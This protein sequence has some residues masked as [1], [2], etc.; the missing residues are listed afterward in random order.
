MD[1]S[2]LEPK[3]FFW[4]NDAETS[5]LNWIEALTLSLFLKLLSRK[6]TPFDSFY[7]ASSSLAVLYLSKVTIWPCTEYYCHIYVADHRCSWEIL[8][9]QQKQL[10]RAVGPSLTDSLKL[11]AHCQNVTCSTFFHSY[12]FGRCSFEVVELISH[13]HSSGIS[14]RYSNVLHNSSAFILRWYK[15]I[16]F[17]S[18]F[19]CTV[20]GWNYLPA[21]CSPLTFELNGLNLELIGTFFPWVFLKQ[22]SYMVFNFQFFFSFNTVLFSEYPSLH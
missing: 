7:E 15:G 22:L 18:W 1:G 3:L 2:V 4:R 5:P 16:N 12:Y 6:W 17:N 10:C 20:R 11:L 14:T 13:P 21:E 19:P 8:N 9:E